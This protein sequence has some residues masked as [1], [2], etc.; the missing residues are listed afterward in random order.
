LGSVGEWLY[1]HVAGIDLDPQT[2]GYG[3]IVIRPHPGGDL[4]HARGEYASVRG[5]IV[6][7]WSIEGD[8]FDLGITIPPNTTA[9]V[10]VPVTGTAG[11]SESEKAVEQAEGVKIL[12]MD[13]GEVVLAVGSGDYEFVGKLAR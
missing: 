13:E 6:S 5:K 8:Q 2:A 7:A 3:H 9:T 12:S 1:R 10:H 11:I 4:T